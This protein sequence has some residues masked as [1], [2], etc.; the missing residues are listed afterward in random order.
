MSGS[1]SASDETADAASQMHAVAPALDAGEVVGGRY[2]IR[3]A[4]GRGATGSVFEAFDLVVRTPVALK[5]LRPEL[6]ADARWI[7][8][9]AAELRIARKIQ[10]PNVCRVFD[11]TAADGRHFLTMEYAGGG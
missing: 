1:S 11:I 8:R 5:L 7:E 9:L 3:R 10:H 6:A 4:V 2:A